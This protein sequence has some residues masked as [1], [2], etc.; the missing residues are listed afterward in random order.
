MAREFLFRQHGYQRAAFKGRK[1]PYWCHPLRPLAVF[2]AKEL[3]DRLLIESLFLDEYEWNMHED[4]YTPDYLIYWGH[5]R[6]DGG[7][8]VS[9][10]QEIKITGEVT[11]KIPDYGRKRTK[12]YR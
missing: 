12:Q 9:T 5:E 2:S 11:G 1:S 4:D 6:W 7:V 8:Y 3:Y 10:L